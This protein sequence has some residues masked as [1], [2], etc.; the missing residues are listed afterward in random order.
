M[1]PCWDVLREAIE[2]KYESIDVFRKQLH[3]Y[4]LST[5]AFGRATVHPQPGRVT[6]EPLPKA[7]TTATKFNL[8]LIGLGAVCLLA[9]L[10]SFRGY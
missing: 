5:H 2:G 4:P 3:K 6:P 10:A 9:S 8:A 7:P 1:G